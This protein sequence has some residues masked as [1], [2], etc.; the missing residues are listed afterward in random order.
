ME[1][2]TAKTMPGCGEDS[3][4]FFGNETKMVFTL[5]PPTTIQQGDTFTVCVS[6]AL[7]SSHDLTET[8]R[9]A[10]A[11]NLSLVDEDNPCPRDGLRG[12]LTSCLQFH[13]GH[14]SHGFAVFNY[15]SI[16]RIGLHRLQV[17]LGAL[18][19]TGMMIE[20]RV[21]SKVFHASLEA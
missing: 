1:T 11:V 17:L 4:R 20:A 16:H 6:V 7:G 13:P 2:R 15:I 12:S 8:Q 5:E 14:P 3:G 10:F 18:S 9:Q 21:V 19:P